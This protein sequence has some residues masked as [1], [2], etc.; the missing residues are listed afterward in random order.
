MKFINF[1]T[2]FAGFFIASILFLGA[3]SKEKMNVIEEDN[4]QEYFKDIKISDADGNYIIYRVSSSEK[5]IVDSYSKDNFKIQVMTQ[6]DLEAK[7][8]QAK[9]QPKI[10]SPNYDEESDWIENDMISV[11]TELIEENIG[12][13]YVTYE[14]TEDWIAPEGYGDKGFDW[15]PMDKTTKNYASL[16]NNR[17]CWAIYYSFDI[18]EGSQV[19]RVED[20]IKLTAG[21]T[22]SRIGRIYGPSDEAQLHIK[23]RKEKQ[24]SFYYYD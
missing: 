21:N 12:K 2:I 24:Y 1:K 20:N 11:S 6:N 15:H 10:D 9:N 17:W 3:C 23:Y 16:T 5:D 14:I 4:S 19:S 7:L 13:E 8:L 18:W 22:T